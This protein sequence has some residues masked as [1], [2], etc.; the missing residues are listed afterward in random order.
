MIVVASASIRTVHGLADRVNGSCFVR[1]RKKYA[2]RPSPMRGARVIDAQSMLATARARGAREPDEDHD[3]SAQR[4]V[5]GWRLDRRK[6]GSCWNARWPRG[7]WASTHSPVTGV[8][9]VSDRGM[10]SVRTWQASMDCAGPRC[11]RRP[12][13]SWWPPATET[14]LI[15]R[16]RGP[17]NGSS[18]CRSLEA[19]AP[20]RGVSA[21]PRPTRP[22]RTSTRIMPACED[23]VGA[24]VS[25]PQVRGPEG[26]AT[27][28]PAGTGCTPK[29]FG[30]EIEQPVGR[31]RWPRELALHHGA[32][33]FRPLRREARTIPVQGVTGDGAGQRIGAAWSPLRFPCRPG[34]R[35]EGPA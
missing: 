20:V 3:R 1:M 29:G 10:L 7:S 31:P 28:P 12:F 23:R 9:L 4:V 8:V 19:G 24:G 16:G 6:C 27:P 21:L 33:R 13:A 25:V 32:A 2:H 26:A 14:R 35:D 30:V 11:G 34:G 18:A 17:A 5:C 15:R 22:D